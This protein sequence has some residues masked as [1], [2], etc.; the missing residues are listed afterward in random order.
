MC[1]SIMR[2]QNSIKKINKYVMNKQPP[3]HKNII[4]QTLYIYCS[5]VR[6]LTRNKEFCYVFVYKKKKLNKMQQMIF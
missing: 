5:K 2:K 1:G 6:I 4:K 3:T